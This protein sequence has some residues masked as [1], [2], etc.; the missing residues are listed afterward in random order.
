MR[1]LVLLSESF[2]APLDLAQLVYMDHAVLHSADL[3]GPE[4]LHPS[5]PAG[6]GELAMRRSLIEQGLAVLLR[7]GL[8][9]VEATPD[10]L[11]YRASEEGPGFVGILTAPYMSDLRSRARWLVHEHGAPEVDARSATLAITNRWAQEFRDRL[12]LAGG[13]HA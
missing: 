10:G 3:G 9:E 5:L 8:A 12:P 4:S 1:T 13:D 2:P 6:P 7:A 11:V